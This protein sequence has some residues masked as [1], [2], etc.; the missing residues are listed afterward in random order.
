M[1]LEFIDLNPPTVV[2]FNC[3]NRKVVVKKENGTQ[4]GL[5]NPKNDNIEF[6][7]SKM[8]KLE[9]KFENNKELKHK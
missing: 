6:R 5:E 3:D 4:Q 8:A 9:I 7:N 2:T 1:L